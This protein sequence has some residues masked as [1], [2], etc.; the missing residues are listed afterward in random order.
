MA[1]NELAGMYLLLAHEYWA[2]AE[3]TTAL[4]AAKT[5][6]AELERLAKEKTHEAD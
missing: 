6:V 3:Y 5:A 1:T 2:E 4:K